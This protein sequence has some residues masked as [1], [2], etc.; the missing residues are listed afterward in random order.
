M[1]TVSRSPIP[2]GMICTKVADS[3]NRDRKKN[4]KEQK[5]QQQRADAHGTHSDH[6]L[7]VDLSVTQT[8]PRALNLS[9]TSS[10]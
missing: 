5:I 2:F 3:S 10:T 6:P 1:R 9:A 7:K 4:D 8:L